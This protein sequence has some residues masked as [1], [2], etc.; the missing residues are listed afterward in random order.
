MH[1]ISIIL[2]GMV[3]NIDNIGIGVSFGTRSRRIPILSNLLIAIL[4][5]TAAYL[6]ITMGKISSGYMSQQHTDLIG[7]MVIIALGIWSM[8]PKRMTK[9][10]TKALPKPID[11][12]EPISWK[13]SISLG[14]ALSVNCIAMGF[15]AGVSGASPIMTAISV[16]VFS[17]IT[18]AIGE[19]IGHRIAMTWLGKYSK[20]IGGLIL[21]AIG[22]YEVFV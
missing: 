8:R 11:F 4:G 10:K 16:G 22:L 1:W 12:S 7:G 15:G 2:I 3:S 18:V 9:V 14:F 19:R 20:A 6:S 17:L 13:E 21:I 5:M